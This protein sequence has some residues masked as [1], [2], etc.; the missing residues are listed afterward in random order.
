MT[1][2]LV[3]THLVPTE[4]VE[5]RKY[6]NLERISAVILQTNEFLLL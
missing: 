5:N 3:H 6:E 4:V 1:I 2:G